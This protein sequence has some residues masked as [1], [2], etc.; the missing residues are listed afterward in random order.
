MAK[1]AIALVILCAVSAQVA[2]A[3]G[4]SEI[5]RARRPIPDQYVVVLAADDPDAVAAQTASLFGG[6]VKHIY[7]NALRGFAIR[8]SAAAAAALANDPRVRHIE[9]DGRVDIADTQVSPP[10]GL[11]RIDDRVLPLNGSYEYPLPATTVYVHVVDTGIRPSHVEFGGRAFIAG[12]YVDDDLDGDPLDVGN[13][14]GDPAV[15]DGADCHGHGTHVAGTIGGTTY[16]VAKNV[17]LYAYRTL[18]CTGEGTISSIIAAV[19]AIT[20]DV[21]RPAVANMSLGGDP[22][23]ALDEAV[24]RSIAAGVTYVVAAGNEGTNASSMS[25]ARVGEAITVGATDASDT[26]PTWSNFGPFL[27]IFAPGVSIR[28]AWHTSDTATAVAS[29][30]SMAAPHTAGVA[31][32]YLGL[33]GDKS[34]TE[35]RDAI[36]L[37]GTPGVV[38]NPGTDSPNL[39]LYSGFLIEDDDARVNVALAANGATATA[40]STDGP[41]YAPSGAIN[42]DRRGADW[43]K[44]G[45]WKDATRY[46][47]P[48]WLEVA[49]AGAKTIDEVAVFSRQDDTESPS[50]PT[51]T[52]TFTR[53]G[54]VDFTVQYWTGSAW[55]AVPGGIVRGNTLV[56]R[57]V[58]F[59]ALTTSRIRVVVEHSRGGWSR[60]IEVEAYEAVGGVVNSPPAVSLTAPSDGAE[61]TAPATIEVTADAADADGSIENVTFYANDVL[62]GMDAAAPYSVNWGGAAI[63]SYVL[64]AVATDDLGTT[65]TSS[66]IT[67]SVVADTSSARVNVAAAANGATAGASSVYK[68]GYAPSGAINGDRRGVNWGT[69]G[70]WKDATRYVFPDWLEVTFAGAKTI[71]EVAVFSRQDDTESPSEPTETMTFTKYGVIDFTVQYWTG[72]AWA[73]VPG[74]IVRGNSLVWRRVTFPA[75]T[76]SGIRV[77]V[78]QGKGGWSRLIEVEAY[79]AP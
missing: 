21:R 55:A 52:M 26:R 29:G 7:R 2:F 68:A 71:D 16:G 58:T 72:S 6:R 40:S 49:F 48:D 53:Y 37:A 20:A 66:A 4:R 5:R 61:F 27:D 78:E 47:F 28:S 56:W 43:G 35:V 34:P 33:A 62:M 46:V 23:D 59:P 39:L 65:T 24:R 75:L 22:S 36:V 13:D 42:G 50:E 74:G 18:D 31:A 57:R 67:I 1:T 14:D 12:D 45:G 9:E 79:E 38:G 70:G 77:L 60:I 11:D 51:E 44:G 25:P 73:A 3:Q 41:G 17:V 8:L 10:W 32:L 54:V 69:A 64:V 19:D 63:G 76:T 30:T 15:P